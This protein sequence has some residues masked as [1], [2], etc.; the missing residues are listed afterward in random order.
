MTK[1][2]ET[3]ICQSRCSSLYLDPPKLDISSDVFPDQ[4]SPLSAR[5]PC[6]APPTG[7]GRVRRPHL[8]T[9]F[10]PKV[11]AKCPVPGWFNAYGPQQYR[12]SS[13]F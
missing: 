8:Q 5:L 11:G 12:G 6:E 1:R 4:E 2:K 3:K 10:C 7:R 13:L 9:D